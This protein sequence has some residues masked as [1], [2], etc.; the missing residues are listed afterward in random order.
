MPTEV[1][2]TV[3]IGHVESEYLDDLLRTEKLKGPGQGNFQYIGE[4][5]FRM[6]EFGVKSRITRRFP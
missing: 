2:K 1:R 4:A 5:A 3:D 6:F